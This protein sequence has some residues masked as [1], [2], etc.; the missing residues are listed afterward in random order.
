MVK[1]KNKDIT[2]RCTSKG[3]SGG[4]PEVSKISASTHYKTCREHLSPFGGLLALIKFLDVIESLK[5]YLRE[6]TTS[7][8]ESP[9]WGITGW[10]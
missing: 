7:R 6:A 2:E 10:W 1:D 5:R 8:S 3:D 9:S 4:N